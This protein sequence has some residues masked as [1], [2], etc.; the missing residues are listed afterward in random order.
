MKFL[1]AALILFSLALAGEDKD[2]NQMVSDLLRRIK[3]ELQTNS[4]AKA[5]FHSKEDKTCQ[6]KRVSL[7][8]AG[9]NALVDCS[10]ITECS[11]TRRDIYIK[12]DSTGQMTLETG[13]NS[14]AVL[15]AVRFCLWSN[16]RLP[17]F[18]EYQSEELRNIVQVHC[19]QLPCSKS[20]LEETRYTLDDLTTRTPA[21]VVDTIRHCFPY[22][23]MRYDHK[24]PEFGYNG[25]EGE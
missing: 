22:M 20:F 1:L 9:L 23:M 13:T 8:E 25:I 4:V 7:R 2:V 16:E 12:E 19:R 5:R 11:A 14:E 10:C 18:I 3:A 15:E 6:L 21:A 17:N 24:P